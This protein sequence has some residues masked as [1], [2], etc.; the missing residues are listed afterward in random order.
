MLHP[1]LLC[2][3]CSRAMSEMLIVGKIGNTKHIDQLM[4]NMY[5]KNNL[6]IFYESG[7]Y[8]TR[9]EAHIDC[10][11]PFFCLFGDER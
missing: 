7:A 10:A 9:C 2:V 5:H 3:F 6:F 1:D 4:N 8:Q 11:S